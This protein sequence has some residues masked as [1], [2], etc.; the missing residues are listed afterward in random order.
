MKLQHKGLKV[1][2]ALVQGLVVGMV[3][4]GCVG[5]RGMADADAHVHHSCHCLTSLPSL[6]CLSWAEWLQAGN[7][8]HMLAEQLARVKEVL[9]QVQWKAFE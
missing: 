3:V 2:A 8:A 1:L 6:T 9:Q 5:H 4:Q 7:E